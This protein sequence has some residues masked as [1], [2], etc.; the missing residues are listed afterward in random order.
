MPELESVRRVGA[1]VLQWGGW[2]GAVFLLIWAPLQYNPSK[3]HFAPQWVSLT[4]IL[5]IGFAIAGTTAR[6]RMRL[7]DTI[8]A[9]MKMGFTL[10]EQRKE[11]E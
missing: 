10:S 6:A 11:E 3:G 8:V 2:G 7:S 4:F 5:C 9:A 1:S